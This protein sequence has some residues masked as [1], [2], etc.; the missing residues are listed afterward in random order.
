MTDL[1]QRLIVANLTLG[2]IFL[3]QSTKFAGWYSTGAFVCAVWF[4]GVAI[5]DITKL[6]KGTP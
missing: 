5:F 4:F 6:G 2:A 1:R 3:I